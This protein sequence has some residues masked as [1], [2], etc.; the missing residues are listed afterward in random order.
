MQLKHTSCT[1][2]RMT[3]YNTNKFIMSRVPPS[4]EKNPHGKKKFAWGKKNPCHTQHDINVRLALF[5]AP[6]PFHFD[7]A[8]L[9]TLSRK[10]LH[11]I[12]T[13]MIPHRQKKT[14]NNDTTHTVKKSQQTATTMHI[15]LE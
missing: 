2:T 10:H 1:Q 12:V 3:A 14:L 5:H 6:A 11:L 7:V 4:G 15:R 8:R 13:R 9:G